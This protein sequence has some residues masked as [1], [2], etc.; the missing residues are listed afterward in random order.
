MKVAIRNLTI[1]AAALFSTLLSAAPATA[2]T[3]P[4]LQ[5][6]AASLKPLP[7]PSPAPPGEQII[8]ERVVR[9]APAGSM[10]PGR[11]HVVGTL[12]ELLANAYD[13]KEPQIAGPSW[14]DTDRFILDA[15]MPPET[16]RPQRLVMLRN[17]LTD[18]FKLATHEETRNLPAYELVLAKEG[19]K[20]RASFAEATNITN[21]RT[22]N[23]GARVTITA[24]AAT[25]EELAAHLTRQLDSPVRDETHSKGKYDFVLTFSPEN[26]EVPDV[27]AALQSQL[28]LKLVSRKAPVEVVVIDHAERTPAAN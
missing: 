11:M 2:Q 18:R 14:M 20:V 25:F 6:D 12:R 8:S 21:I 4:N 15:K 27:F 16:T 9:T 3:D 5:F 7:P 28:G 13:V 19:I 22:V 23:E 17:L 1:P 24:Q 10:D 26:T